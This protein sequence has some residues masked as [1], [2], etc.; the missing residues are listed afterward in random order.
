MLAMPG[1][2]VGVIIGSTAGGADIEA[3]VF[4]DLAATGRSRTALFAAR[5]PGAWALVL[6]M[7]ALAWPSPALVRRARRRARARPRP[8]RD[9]RRRR[10]PPCSPPARCSAAVCVGL[11]ALTGSR[12]MVIGV[13]LAFQLG[14]S[15]LL[16]ADRRAR[17][18]PPRDPADG[19]RPPGRP[20]ELAQQ[21]G[22]ATAVAIVL[23]LVRRRRWPRA[24]GAPGPRRS[25]LA[26][27]RAWAAAADLVVRRRPARR[28]GR[29]AGG[30]RGDPARRAVRRCSRSS[31]ST[32]LAAHRPVAV[33]A[34]GVA[35]TAAR[36][37]PPR[38]SSGTRRCG[39]RTWSPPSRLCRRGGRVRPLRRARGAAHAARER[40]LLAERA[41][42]EE[43]LRIARELHDAVG[44]DVSLMVVQAQALGA[45]AG[46]DARPRG[47]GRDRGPGPPHD[48]RDAPHAAAA[49]RGADPRA[50]AGIDGL[51]D[52]G[53]RRARGGRRR[54]A[55]RRGR[56][57]RRSP[58]ALGAIGVPDRPGGGDERRPARRRRAR[59]GRGALPAR[60][61]RAASPT[62]APGRHGDGA[63]G[64]HG[65][66]GHARAGRAF[67]GTLE[68]GRRDE[69]RLRGPRRAAPDEE[70]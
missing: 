45:T 62:R 48:G 54:V 68:A 1:S 7:L 67:G 18:R 16:A 11:A 3:G 26:A 30:R 15:P 4:R 44:H 41:A 47:D 31:R 53:G 61:A 59:H 2:V 28:A 12:G 43:R 35:A 20:G 9:A 19:R 27:M 13:V 63:P 60:R 33:A 57:A 37:R 56:P 58:P 64:G 40:E 70:P 65:L 6:P 39:S 42:A 25:R 24:P 55:R 29:R 21:F 22:L 66:V 17:R 5:V 10:R 14:V 34:A 50:G 23:G 49:A 52:G 51:D 46:D 69:R 32:A 38:A 8:A 36:G